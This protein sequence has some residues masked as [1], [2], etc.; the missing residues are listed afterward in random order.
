MFI[1]VEGIKNLVR[2]RLV[3]I[4]VVS[5]IGTTLLLGSWFVIVTYSIRDYS[6]FFEPA[7][8][9]EAFLHD[10]LSADSI[11]E[12]N[13]TLSS[14]PGI[15]SIHFISKD[16]A[17]ILFMQ[18]VGE[19][20]KTLF[21]ENILPPSF[22]IQLTPELLHP[23]LIDSVIQSLTT[24]DGIDE[25]VAQKEL[26]SLL[27]KY[28]NSAWITLSVLGAAAGILSLVLLN[29]AIKLS[30]L[31]CKKSIEVMKLVGASSG[32]IKGQFLVEGAAAGFLGGL[33][34]AIL[35]WG[36]A[37]LFESL[38]GVL[39]PVPYFLYYYSIPAGGL[40]GVLGSAAAVRRYI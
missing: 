18:E 38:A 26:I 25:V 24:I 23:D 5:V 32:F 35:M 28:R 33:V 2:T 16:S 36:F 37:A 14:N 31:T 8:E 6:G 1:I 10:T 22:K 9:I 40:L 39:L 13:K 11:N 17:A 3:G 30:V 12:L 19:D 15:S 29:N 4:M 20:I 27:L 34:S 7:T 21:G